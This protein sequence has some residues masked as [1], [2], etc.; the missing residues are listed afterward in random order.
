MLDLR[1]WRLIMLNGNEISLVDYGVTDGSHFNLFFQLPDN[2]NN[3]NNNRNDG[4]GDNVSIV[5]PKT[6]VSQEDSVT[7]VAK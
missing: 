7:N 3:N 2:N 5:N 4:D 6:L 1:T